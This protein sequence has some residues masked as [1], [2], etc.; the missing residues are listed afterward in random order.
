[1]LKSGVSIEQLKRTKEF[2]N[3]KQLL[4]RMSYSSS[5]VRPK[6]IKFEH[7]KFTHGLE[8][9]LDRYVGLRYQ[10]QNEETKKRRAKKKVKK[11]RKSQKLI[12]SNDDE[13]DV[14][15]VPELTQQ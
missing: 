6:K 14:E 12:E 4:N 3:Q 11:R 10:T 7:N 13:A 9:N 15:Q 1:M 2:A 8:F 5:N